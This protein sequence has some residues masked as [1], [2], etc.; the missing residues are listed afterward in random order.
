VTYLALVVYTTR[1]QGGE[2]N[3][4]TVSCGNTVFDFATCFSGGAGCL[5]DWT[6]NPQVQSETDSVKQRD[7]LLSGTIGSFLKYLRHKSLIIPSNNPSVA[8][9]HRRGRQIVR[10]SYVFLVWSWNLGF[11]LIAVLCWRDGFEV[12]SLFSLLLSAGCFLCQM[13]LL[14]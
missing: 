7:I 9:K 10:P 6:I 11:C 3:D 8:S 4:W 12:I 2:Q 5:F 1:L 14:P 13:F